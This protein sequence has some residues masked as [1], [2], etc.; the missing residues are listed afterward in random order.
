MLYQYTCLGYM[1]AKANSAAKQT[2]EKFS[3]GGIKYEFVLDKD[4]NYKTAKAHCRSKGGYL[5]TISNQK[6]N[7]E[8]HRRMI[9]A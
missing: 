9:A 8:L 4:V 7:H 2:N 5:A 6:L 3:F 1:C